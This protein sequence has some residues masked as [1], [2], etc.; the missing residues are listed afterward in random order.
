MD[1][2]LSIP[3]QIRSPVTHDWSCAELNGS[4]IGTCQVTTGLPASSTTQPRL[5]ERAWGI[6][7]ADARVIHDACCTHHPVRRRLRTLRP[8]KRFVLRRDR[9]GS[10]GSRRCKS[11]LAAA[12]FGGATG[13]IRISTPCSFVLNHDLTKKLNRMNVSCR[14]PTQ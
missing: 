8:L 11:P 9:E 4:V 6:V 13:P 12:Y 3:A 5:A 7:P 10:S 1:R 14:V 2:G